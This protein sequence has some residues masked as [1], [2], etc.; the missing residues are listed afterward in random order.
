M[1][2]PDSEAAAPE[3]VTQPVISLRGVTRRF[4][5]NVEQDGPLTIL[6]S[7]DLDILPGSFTVIRGES[8]SG[9]TTLLRILGMLDT[10]Y[11][12]NYWLGTQQ[13]SGQPD[14]QIDEMRAENLG[15]IFQ[16]GRLFS[17][18]TLEQNTAVV[19]ALHR[20][21]P[22]GIDLARTFFR[23]DEL[24][25][26]VLKKTPGQVSGGQRQRA[27]ILRALAHGPA[28]ILAD[29][30]TASLHA[31]L[32][33]GIV[34]L[35]RELCELGCTVVVVSHDS[36]FY[37]TGRQLEL[38][39]GRLIELELGPQGAEVVHVPVRLPKPGQET[40]WGWKP[41]APGAML[42]A[43][44]WRESFQ[45]PLFLFL[46]LAAL[47]V[48]V[49]QIS[50]FGSVILGTDAFVE[51]KIAEGSRLN[52][53][54]ITPRSADRAAEDRFPARAE[55]TTWT[56]VET[57]VPRRTTTQTLVTIDGNEVPF[58]A[59]GL[60]PDDPE[61][62]LL[63][64]VA[65]GP[66]SGAHDSLE[67]MLTAN[68]LPTLF[69]VADLQ[70]GR[71]DFS[72]FIGR[73]VEV[74]VP[75]FASGGVEVGQ[76]RARLSVRGIILHGEGG[77]QIYMPNRTQL[78]LDGIK[79]D[80]TGSAPNPFSADGLAWSDTAVR[81][82]L[83][84]F[85]W[86]D[87]L[88]IYSREIREI[89]PTYRVL[90]RMGYSPKSDIWTFKWALDIQ[91]TAWRIF[92]P[93]LVLIIVLVA[94]TVFANIFTSAKMRESELALWRVLGMRRGDIVLTQVASTLM[95]VVVGA[96][97]GLLGGHGFVSYIRAMLQ[98]KSE[99]VAV[100]QEPTNFDAIFADVW[101][102]AP[103]VLAGAALVGIVAA[104]YPAYRA[105]RVDP[106]KVLRT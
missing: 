3:V 10:D 76:E 71:E 106:A 22:D 35:L 87:R 78:A 50:V 13:V 34:H 104:I 66:F 88:H 79:M 29:E 18:L 82:R 73:T 77:R 17:H 12:G 72:Q 93:L 98:A 7:V 30:P 61:Y 94:S 6:D 25:S 16:E 42:F 56:N 32:K 68:V 49:C 59:L 46:I 63:S 90:A 39:Q 74:V 26:A 60:H 27:S 37:D 5:G 64:F 9:K 85:P 47:I 2:R 20:K 83:A 97:I 103:M 62:R 101:G 14:W 8:G 80:R 48:G 24:E 38:K 53:I 67:V 33:A 28:I 4:A 23:A 1:L 31:D 57:V 55:I 69:D 91:D 89:I 54:E 51:R 102:F 45:R 99:D 11:S 92:Q 21:D 44:A 100:G 81:D 96:V 70:A 40:L 19:L 43:Q 36:V 41:R 86:E 65:G 58:T 95:S 105:A 52:R 15:F 75:R 84:D